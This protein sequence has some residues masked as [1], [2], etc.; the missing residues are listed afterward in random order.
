MYRRQRRI[1]LVP[2]RARSRAPAHGSA[3]WVPSRVPE[4]TVQVGCHV[5]PNP[6]LGTDQLVGQINTPFESYAR[7]DEVVGVHVGDRVAGSALRRPR[8]IA[9]PTSSS[10]SLGMCLPIGVPAGVL[11]LVNFTSVFQRYKP[12]STL[13]SP[14][15]NILQKLTASAGFAAPYSKPFSVAAHEICGGRR[16]LLHEILVRHDVAKRAHDA[17]VSRIEQ[18]VLDSRLVEK[19]WLVRLEADDGVHPARSDDAGVET[20]VNGLHIS[21]CHTVLGQHGAHIASDRAADTDDL[22]FEFRD[23]L[24]PV[25]QQDQLG[26]ARLRHRRHDDDIRP[27]GDHLCVERCR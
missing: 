8:V 7:V 1:R 4:L 24:D 11:L 6:L 15:V 16:V 27:S 13:K 17:V 25:R 14:C 18:L 10:H 21:G 12:P 2:A 19:E 23:G 20:L 22:P 9:T 5:T 3:M 26:R